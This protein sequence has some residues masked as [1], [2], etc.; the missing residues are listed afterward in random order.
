[1]SIP[2]VAAGLFVLWY[3]ASSV[4]AWYQLRHIPGPFFARFSNLWPA[5]NLVWTSQA[6]SR[7]RKLDKKYGPIVRVGPNQVVTSDPDMIRAINSARSRYPRD[8]WNK[9]GKFHPEY[10]NVF[11]MCEIEEHD[12]FK[13]KTQSA[14]SGRENGADLEPAIDSE[15]TKFLS[16]VR[17]KYLSTPGSS[18]IVDISEIM[19][20][21]TMDIITRLAY[22]KSF[23]HLDEG[24][25]VYDWVGHSGPQLMKTVTLFMELPLLRRIVFSPLGIRL[26]GAKETDKSGPGKIMGVVN[27]LI[28]ERLQPD[29]KPKNDMI[30]A[31]IRN[32]MTR[33]EMEGEAML[34]LIAGS[35]TTTNVLSVTLM[36]L[37]STPHAYARLKREISDAMTTGTVT[38]SSEGIVPK[39]QAMKLPYLQGVLQEGLRFTCPANYGHYKNV[40]AGG[41]TFHGFYLPEGTAVGNNY[42]AVFMSKDI[43]GQ[44][45]DVFRPERFCEVDEAT[46]SRRLKALDITFGGGRWM[47]S[48]KLI[49]S[50][51][52]NKVIFELVR[53]FDM[54]MVEPRRGWDE[55][56]YVA[57]KFENML[58]RITEADKPK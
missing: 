39:D 24:I 40:P 45:A 3:V 49:A 31:F 27:K 29:A 6:R 46:R 12:R 42:S 5:Y 18:R 2:L 36:H 1:M 56:H 11:T 35:D 21:V 23:G 44:D 16:L 55:Y 28:R 22:G 50:L 13:A 51:E 19:R 57:P 32:G 20:Y 30:G 53:A 17:R 52:M 4:K 58:V 37:I 10:E 34:Q 43:F 26:V 9:G 15:I 48:G 47:C 7:M 14:Y 41:E 25:D 38:L 8:E 33:G 54:Q